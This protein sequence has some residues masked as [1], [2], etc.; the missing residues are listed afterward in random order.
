MERHVRRFARAAADHAGEPEDP[1]G[2]E[3]RTGQRL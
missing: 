3:R 2:R 1:P